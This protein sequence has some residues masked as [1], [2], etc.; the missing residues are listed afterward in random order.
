MKME[1]KEE[2]KWRME[3]QSADDDREVKGQEERGDEVAG[4]VDN[5]CGEP[6]PGTWRFPNGDRDG[7][8]C[9]SLY[10]VA[11]LDSL[12]NENYFGKRSEAQPES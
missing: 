1:L 11:V 6:G 8:Y 4:A 12:L 7:R 9:R 2:A 10:L 3:I 5:I